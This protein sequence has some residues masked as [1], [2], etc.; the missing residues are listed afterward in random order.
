MKK[1][2]ILAI[3]VVLVLLACGIVSILTQTGGN[4]TTKTISIPKGFNANNIT[5]LLYQEE[6]IRNKHFFKLSTRFLGQQNNLQAGVYILSGNMTNIAIINKLKLGEVIP[7]NLMKITFPEGSSVYRMGK[8]LKELSYEAY[9]KFQKLYKLPIDK[10][11]KKEYAFLADVGQNSLEGY[12]FPDTYLFDPEINEKE[13]SRIMLNRFTE[14][15]IHYWLENANNTKYNLH[16]ILTLASIIEKEAQ[17]PAE[18]AII[19]SVYH[20]RLNIGMALDACPTIKYALNDP[21][22]RVFLWQLKVKSPY[23][24]YINPGLPPGPICNPG[25]ES[26]KAAIYPL[27]TKYF[28]FVAKKDGSHIFSKTLAEH[29]RSRRSIPT[30]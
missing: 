23:N 2:L 16:Q 25:I 18:R 6:I 7:P 5:N 9:S 13:L 12:L 15:V 29:N 8:I 10:E 11:L 24:T 26:I 20:N 28:F 27:K 30:Q 4:G 14:V 19:S 3:P 21:T 1:K 22:K 17:K